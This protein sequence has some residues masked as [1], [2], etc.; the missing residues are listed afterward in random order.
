MHTQ[1]D[2]VAHITE[3]IEATGVVEDAA[4]EYDLDAIAQA[5]YIAA[6]RSW[7]ITDV[8]ASVFWWCVQRHALNDAER[9]AAPEHPEDGS[10]ATDQTASALAEAAERVAA[11]RQALKAAESERDQLLIRTHRTGAYKVTE[12]AD[13]AGLTR[14]RVSQIVS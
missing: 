11:A 10:D 5:L 12:L 3:A 9:D 14:A 6:G 8:D 4:A 2:A 7:D 1:S 13:M